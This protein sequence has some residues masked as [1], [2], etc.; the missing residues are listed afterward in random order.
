MYV[1][2]EKGRNEHAD[3]GEDQRATAA[4]GAKTGWLTSGNFKL[5]LSH[6]GV[7]YCAKYS[8]LFK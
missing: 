6:V 4:N 7:T 2:I 5:T 3:T 1:C 8:C